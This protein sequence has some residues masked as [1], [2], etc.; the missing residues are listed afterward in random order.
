MRN[1]TMIGAVLAT[2]ACVPAA[3]EV[4]PEVLPTL[5]TATVV[6]DSEDGNETAEQ[7]QP[8]PT[9]ETYADPSRPAEFTYH[10]EVIQG[11]WLRGLAP[12]GAVSLAVNGQRVPMSDDG[13]FFIAF[14]R[15]SAP[16]ARLTAQLADGSLATKDVSVAR[17]DWGKENINLSRRRGGPSSAF[18]QRR[19]PELAQIG[20]ARRVNA[21]SDGWKQDFIWPAKGRISSPFGR[22]RLYRGEPG[23]YHSGIDIAPGH[24]VPFVA[25]AD[26]VVTLATTRPFSLEG[27]LIIIDH[28]NGL[29]S[30][31]LHCSKIVVAQGQ[32]VKQ[33]QHI[34]NIGSSGS[35]TGPHLHWGLKWN[36][37]RLDPSL[38]VGPM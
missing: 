36:S 5:A 22:T 10:G 12:A 35:A 8:S 27:Y 37:A 4:P 3:E 15:D 26:G 6:E 2:A 9:L 38:F 20:A 7:V 21:K 13:Q 19:R 28:G 23:G 25:P 30:A 29:N 17:R 33:G 32:T 14:D 16:L 24:G 1:F 34:G 31:F 18:M 11:G